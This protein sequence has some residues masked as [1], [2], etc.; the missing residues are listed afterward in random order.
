MV[1]WGKGD[2]PHIYK[3]AS[4]PRMQQNVGSRL[5][6]DL[7]LIGHD[8]VFQWLDNVDVH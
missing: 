8:L 4:I 7:C 3:F 2:K 1:I 6:H 5:I